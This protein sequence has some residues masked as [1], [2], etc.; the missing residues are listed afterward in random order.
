[1][2]RH[3]NP[4]QQCRLRL[5]LMASLA[6]MLGSPAIEARAI[7]DAASEPQKPVSSEA[8]RLETINVREHVQRYVVDDSTVATKTPTPLLET[9]QSVS[10]ITRQQMNDQGVQNVGEALLYTAGTF[11]GLVGSAT[12][13]DYVA[14]RGFNDGETDNTVLDG[15]K[16]LSDAGSYSSMQIDPYF[17]E[18]VEVF[19]GPSSVLYGRASPGGLVALSSKQPLDHPYHAFEIGY[20]SQGQ[21]RVG[22][23]L[24]GP[25]GRSGRLSYRL[26]GLYRYT[27]TQTHHVSSERQALMPEFTYRFTQDT[28]LSVQVMLQNDPSGGQHGGLP[29]DATINT[30]HNGHR[31]SRHFFDGDPAQ[32]QFFRKQRMFGYSFNHRFNEH[33]SLQQNFRYLRSHVN[34]K[35]VYGYGWI[36]PDSD[37]LQR[38]YSGADERLRAYAV[39]THVLGQFDSGPVSHTLLAGVDY[40]QRHNTGAWPSGLA[41]PINPFQPSYGEPGVDIVSVTP[42]L[43]RLRQTGLYLQDQLVWRQWH[44]LLSLRHDLAQ[45]RESEDGSTRMNQGQWSKRG[46]LLYL[47]KNGLAPYASYSEAFN[48]NALSGQDGRLLPLS[49]SKQREFGLKYEPPGQPYMMTLAAYDLLQ[50]HVG[51][52]IMNTSYYEAVGTIRSRGLEWEG[53]AQLSRQW[54]LLASYTWTRMHYVNGIDR[55]HIPYQSPHDMASAWA[56]YASDFGWRLGGGIRYIGHSWADSANTVKVPSYTLADLSLDYD[57]GH[58]GKRWQGLSA[59]LTLHNLTNRSYVASCAQLNFCY[60]GEVRNIMANLRYQF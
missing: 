48:P 30:D 13:F 37:D 35:Q 52:R 50:H 42:M 49:S 28:S 34:M 15:L 56:Q 32:D 16:V 51:T 2:E 44:L 47:F 6:L 36:S 27:D 41:A 39:D 10:V 22:F 55:G 12:R 24:S 5:P 17:L 53:H 14:L 43:R 45:V 23:D 4:M 19:R 58:A 54:S 59:Q 1:M 60:Y 8:K 20:G 7:D 3:P 33:W 57:F 31:I 11:T 25:L 9:P 18:R 46:G 21:K 26:L 29:A 38:Y 40:Q